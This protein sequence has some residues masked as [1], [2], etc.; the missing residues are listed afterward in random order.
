[1]DMQRQDDA[2]A[3]KAD[4]KALLSSFKEELKADFA[5]KNDL[6]GFAK[7]DD[8]SGFAMKSDLADFAKKDDLSGFATKSDLADF[9]KKD[10]LTRFATKDDLAR[11]P[12]KD[13]LTHFATKDDLARLPTKDDLTRFATKDDLAR[14]PTKDDLLAVQRDLERKIALEIVKTHGRIDQLRDD[15]RGE[16]KVLASGIYKKIDGFMGKIGK[17]DRAQVIADW[18][19]SQLEKRTDRIES[20]PS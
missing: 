16:M 10:D 11:L 17:I 13:D 15:L 6:A 20:R 19:V 5:T 8:L 2:P 4:I 12:T 18:R 1:M 3:T 14:L 7:K 9:A